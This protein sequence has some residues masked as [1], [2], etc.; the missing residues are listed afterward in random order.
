MPVDL[1]NARERLREWARVY[2]DTRKRGQAGSAES[3]YLSPQC[4]EAPEP[5]AP[6]DVRRAHA[7]HALLKQLPSPN[8]RALTF[9][10]CWPWL[11][12]AIPLRHL[13]RRLGYRINLTVY[14]DLIAIGEHRLAVVIDA[15][16]AKWAT[17]RPWSGGVDA[18][19]VNMSPRDGTATV[20]ASQATLRN[21]PQEAA[22][23]G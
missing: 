22:G 19:R 6:L 7:T 4:W 20:A 13:S 23:Y 16:Q 21:G 3:K 18:D 9:R 12:V 10:Y 17:P 14:D 5:R 15:S 2:R 11:P 8:F 1:E